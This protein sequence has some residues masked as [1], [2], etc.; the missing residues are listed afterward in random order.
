MRD[1][2][3]FLAKK[4]ARYLSEKLHTR[5]EIGSVDIEFFKKLV[6]E[7]VYIEDLHHDTLFYAQKL[8]LDISDFNIEQRKINIASVNLT[9]SKVALIQYIDEDY[10]NLQ[11]ILDAFNSKDTTKKKP[12]DWD[13]RFQNLTLENTSFIYHRQSH[14]EISKG[15]NYYDIHVKNMN[16]VIN[17]IQ[18]EHDTIHAV[19][20]NLSAIEKSGFTLKNF[21]SVVKINSIGLQLKELKIETP[22]SKIATNLTFKYNTYRDFNDFV[23]QITLKADFDR[24]VLEMDDIAY[25]APQIKG[26][27]QK[28]L[29]SGQISG[30]VNNLRGKAM[31]ILLHNTQTQ[32]IG[33]IK[34]TGLPKIE[35]T[36]IYLNVEQ[37]KTNYNDL[38][39]LAIP[40]FDKSQTLDVP[41]NVAKLGNMKFKGTFTGLYN[42]FYAY[43]NFSSAL[44]KLYMDLSVQHDQKLNK[45]FYKGKL[46]STAF[47]FGEFF[48]VPML[49]KATANITVDG[50]GLTVEKVVA[51]LKGTI[52][53]LEFNEYTYKNIAVEGDIA[54]QI[55][56]GKLNVK[57]ENVDFDF[58]GNIDFTGELPNLDFIS[59]LERADLVALNFLK[60]TKKTNKS[61]TK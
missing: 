10:L 55:F 52:N 11:F 43:G 7:D 16:S 47:D 24:S 19:I 49:G 3:V 46:K 59:T 54:K 35:E 12:A 48:G 60:T 51:S 30:R 42:D 39:Q 40:P 2:Q 21:S 20:E 50:T 28:L 4:G 58:N 36:L 29:V 13:I 57:D 23:N 17:T 1:V 8:K 5:V 9:N 31:N 53:S 37:L 41:A 32:F 34:L 22:E 33:D 45:E 61:K 26:M 38:K 25:F 14:T 56:K 18:I 44:G 15:I 27:Y 6:L